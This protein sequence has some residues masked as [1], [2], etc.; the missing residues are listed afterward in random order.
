MVCF[1]P[2]AKR[3]FL[4]AKNT[5]YQPLLIK[6]IFWK[7]FYKKTTEK[8]PCLQIPNPDSCMVESLNIC[9]MNNEQSKSFLSIR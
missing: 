4:Q 6:P 2:I 5:P 3:H 8:M 9:S 7:H 1:S